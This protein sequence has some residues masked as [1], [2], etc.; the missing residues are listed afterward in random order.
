MKCEEDNRESEI[1]FSRV[2]KRESFR[3]VD[4]GEIVSRI[5]RIKLL[6]TSSNELQSS[7]NM[8]QGLVQELN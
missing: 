3:K 4:C 6:E 7:S 5:G 2:V 8:I 1:L